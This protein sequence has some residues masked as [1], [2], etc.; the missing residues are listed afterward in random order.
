MNK[1]GIQIESDVVESDVVESDVVES[2]VVISKGTLCMYVSAFCAAYNYCVYVSMHHSPTTVCV[3]KKLMQ[4]HV[5]I[6]QKDNKPMKTP[7]AA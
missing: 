7:T 3:Y 2:D 6:R 5:A 4:G 1:Y